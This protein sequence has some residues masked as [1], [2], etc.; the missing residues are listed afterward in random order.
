MPSQCFLR[1]FCR[2]PAAFGAFTTAPGSTTVCAPV[3]VKATPESVTVCWDPNL[4]LQK[5]LED[6]V[7]VLWLGLSG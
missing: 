7:R 5:R 1:L 4:E 2:S 6:L 3:C